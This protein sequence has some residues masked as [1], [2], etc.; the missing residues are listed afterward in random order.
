M[1]LADPILHC[2]IFL[3]QTIVKQQNWYFCEPT[4]KTMGMKIFSIAGIETYLNA[5]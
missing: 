3:I 2:S 1:L 5:G 4:Q